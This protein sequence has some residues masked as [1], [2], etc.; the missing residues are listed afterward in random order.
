LSSHQKAHVTNFDVSCDAINQHFLTVAEKTVADLPSSSVFPLSYIDCA[1][2]PDL[3]L[4]KVHIDDVLQYI[5]ALDIHKAVGVDEIP[6][7]FVKAA[8]YGM[9]VILTRLLNMSI[10]TCTFPGLWKTA[11]VTPVQKSKQNSSLGN[12]RP[13]SILP[14]VSKILERLVFD[15]MVSHLLKYELLSTKQPGFRPGHSMQDV[16]L[17]VTDSWLNAIDDGKF[18]GTVN[19]LVQCFSILLKRLTVLTMRYY[20]RS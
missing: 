8:P 10:Q 3:F 6:T 18:V 2:V 11:I 16:L 9:T 5:Q 13:I 14:V 7:R 17:S 20:Y 4:S 1:D 19:L 12:F 15:A